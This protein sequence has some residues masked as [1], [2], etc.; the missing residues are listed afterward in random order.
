MTNAESRR[1]RVLKEAMQLGVSFAAPLGHL[2]KGDENA[3]VDAD[4]PLTSHL[5]EFATS[6]GLST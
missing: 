6:N 1:D 4:D 2:V 5:R 3:A